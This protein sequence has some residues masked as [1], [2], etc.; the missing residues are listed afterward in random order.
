MNQDNKLPKLLLMGL[1]ITIMACSISVPTKSPPVRDQIIKILF[2]NG[3]EEGDNANHFRNIKYNM[4][5]FTGNGVDFSIIITFDSNHSQDKQ[6]QIVRSILTNLYPNGIISFYDKNI[7]RLSNNALN[8]G[9]PLYV[10]T[11]WING[12]M[13]GM[14][15]I[16]MPGAVEV[17]IGNPK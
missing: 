8:G 16:N 14:S 3:F 4:I 9:D 5:A 7:R 1:I 13:V 17:A 12:Y 2:S 6:I 15:N 10:P 11:A